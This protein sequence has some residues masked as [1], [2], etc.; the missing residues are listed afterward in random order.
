LPDAYLQQV[1]A[2]NQIEKIDAEIDKAIQNYLA[3]GCRLTGEEMPQVSA[4]DIN[5]V[6]LLS[7]K[8]EQ[9]SDT[10]KNDYKINEAIWH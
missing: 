10:P 4:I 1:Y 2:P 9:K 8:H 5:V 6:N 7:C 3:D